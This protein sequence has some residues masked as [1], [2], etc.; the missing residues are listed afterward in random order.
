[1]NKNRPK[2]NSSY[3]IR[4]VLGIDFMGIVKMNWKVT[5]EKAKNILDWQPKYP[6]YKGGIIVTLDE[7]KV[8]KK[9]F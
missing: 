6:S 1:M 5:N 3:V 8:R 7:M 9:L 2:H 4:L